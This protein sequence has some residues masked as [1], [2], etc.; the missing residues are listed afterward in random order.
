MSMVGNPYE[1]YKQSAVETAPPEKLLLM[2][3]DG[4]I[5]F[6]IQARQAL[7][8]KDFE[9]GNRLNLQVQDILAELI[10]SL[11]FS[12]G[13]IPRKLSL[14]YDFYQRQLILA[15]L[16]KDPKL[17]DPVLNFFQEYKVLWEEVSRLGKA[18]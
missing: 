11:D 14:L 6:L 8:S 4:A 2:L 7:E 10:A 1:K 17:I 3:Y 12:Y 18:G 13:E 9:A 5:K 16:K 15:N